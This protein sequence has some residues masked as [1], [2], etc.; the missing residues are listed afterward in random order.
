MKNIYLQKGRIKMN[1]TKRLMSIVL[2]VAML[3]T[4]LA[5]AGLVA[6]A[7]AGKE[8]KTLFDADTDCANAVVSYNMNKTE[9]NLADVPAE[10]TATTVA[11]TTTAT[12]TTAT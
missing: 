11:P 10:T 6:S 9:M 3:I 1:K 2:S 5:V 8:W 7:D 4:T 12:P